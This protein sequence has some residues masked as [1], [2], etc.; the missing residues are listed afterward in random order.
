MEA[1]LALAHR[2]RS[3][4]RRHRLRL[5]GV[6]P[7]D[8][9]AL[10]LTARECQSLLVAECIGPS[11]PRRCPAFLARARPWSRPELRSFAPGIDV[12]LAT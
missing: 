12:T 4:S 1:A 9:S 3:A 6:K 10:R 7:D 2:I 8:D 5:D 11:A